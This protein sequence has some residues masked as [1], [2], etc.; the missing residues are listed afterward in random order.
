MSDREFKRPAS[1]PI[2][3]S[4]INAAA[5]KGETPFTFDEF[6]SEIVWPFE[7]WG[8][9]GSDS[10]K[11][12]EDWGGE[13]FDPTDHWGEAQIRIAEA[14]EAAPNEGDTVQLTLDDWSKFSEATKAGKLLGPYAPKLRVMARAIRN[15]TA[16]KSDKTP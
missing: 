16:V 9:G 7:K 12:A 4:R 11:P 6:V 10:D 1:F 2:D 14:L 3:R 5:P 13:N 15:A 8:G